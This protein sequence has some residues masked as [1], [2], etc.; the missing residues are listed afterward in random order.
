[1]LANLKLRHYLQSG[2]QDLC[3]LAQQR[4][5]IRSPTSPVHLTTVRQNTKGEKSSLERWIN[6]GFALNENS[7]YIWRWKWPV[8]CLLLPISYPCIYL[9]YFKAKYRYVAAKLQFA[10]ETGDEDL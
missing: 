3:R 7:G 5:G 9:F 2:T 8:F 1:M 6:F 4:G 10:P